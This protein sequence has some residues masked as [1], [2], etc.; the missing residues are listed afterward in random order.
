MCQRRQASRLHHFF[1]SEAHEN[2][3]SLALDGEKQ[4][5]MS[6]GFK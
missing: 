3:F 2:G 1:H 4:L 6:V 5:N